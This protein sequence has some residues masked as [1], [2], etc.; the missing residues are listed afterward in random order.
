M[1]GRSNF[2]GYGSPEKLEKAITAEEDERF[3]VYT[4]GLCYASVCSNLPQE[5]VIARMRRRPSGT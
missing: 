5:E 1:I 3:T 2:A 4:E